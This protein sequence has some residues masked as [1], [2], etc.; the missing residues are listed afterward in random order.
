MANL[1]YNRTNV[2]IVDEQ[3]KFIED[4]DVKVMAHYSSEEN[5]FTMTTPLT[6]KVD[7]TPNE[8]V[9]TSEV[10]SLKVNLHKDGRLG[11]SGKI[12]KKMVRDK[13]ADAIMNAFTEAGKAVV[14]HFNK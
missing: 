14:N 5:K 12:S 4:E 9:Y 10:I 13:G 2:T 6:Q 3:N 8:S 1:N 11:P 7:R